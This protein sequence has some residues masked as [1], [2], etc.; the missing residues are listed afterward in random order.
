MY[1]TT[2]C[3]YVTVL[4]NHR[5]ESHLRSINRMMRWEIIYSLHHF[6]FIK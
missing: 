1:A 4:D 6:K 5:R 3:G 2:Q